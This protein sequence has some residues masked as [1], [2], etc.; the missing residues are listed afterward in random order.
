[1]HLHNNYG[2]CSEH[3][4]Y[5]YNVLLHLLARCFTIFIS[6]G[7][8]PESLLSVVLIYVIKDKNVKISSKDN[9][10]PIALPSLI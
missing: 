9:Y 6:H 10:H 7:F 2:I 8:L 1:M 3:L 4:K 5:T